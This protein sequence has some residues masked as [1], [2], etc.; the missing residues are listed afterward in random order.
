[1]TVLTPWHFH[2][3]NTL[4]FSPYLHLAILTV[5]TQVQVQV[6]ARAR[7]MCLLPTYLVGGPV[8]D[9]HPG[10]NAQTQTQLIN[11]RILFEFYL[12]LNRCIQQPC[13]ASL[14]FCIDKTPSCYTICLFVCLFVYI[15]PKTV[16]NYS[17]D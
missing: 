15:I 1:M 17:V 6:R 5:L 9:F 4:S 12:K 11:Y 14:A 2:R 16:A 13:A 8:G 3:T 7:G 10:N